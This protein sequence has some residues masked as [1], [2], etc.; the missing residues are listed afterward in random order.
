MLCGK[1]YLTATS[2]L[3]LFIFGSDI[4]RGFSL[5]CHR[6]EYQIGDR[7]CP[8]CPPGSRVKTDCAEFLRTSCCSCDEGTFM[9]QYTGLKKCFPCS[10][11]DAGSGLKIKSSCTD[12]SD[13]ICEPLEGFYCIDSTDGDCAAAQRHTSCQPGQYIAQQ[14]T[15]LEDTVCLDC[16]SGTFS[17]GTVES[18]RPHTQC[19]SLN[20]WLI[21][22]GTA[23]SDNECGE[24]TSN[25]TGIIVAPI[26]GVV[27]LSAA[28]VVVIYLL[29]VRKKQIQHVAVSLETRP[30][31]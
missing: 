16:S 7:C 8:I 14:G 25:H 31:W 20:L 10:T 6:S 18:C 2:L 28:V 22:P 5:S 24:Q 9:N 29:W 12:T 21:T 15:D 27:G 17:N 19:E 1:K 3:I 30:D 4:V 23:S 11:C 26:L 13:T